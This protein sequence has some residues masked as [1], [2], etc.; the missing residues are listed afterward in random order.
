MCACRMFFI[1]SCL[2]VCA[3]L[4]I[5][6]DHPSFSMF[7]RALRFYLFSFF[8]SKQKTAYEFRISDWSSDVCSS[9]LLDF[10]QDALSHCLETAFLCLRALAGRLFPAFSFQRLE[11]CAGMMDHP[12]S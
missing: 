2:F 12:P 11:Q 10:S 1:Y 9:D 7:I 3:T 4:Y 5:L 8:F 6:T